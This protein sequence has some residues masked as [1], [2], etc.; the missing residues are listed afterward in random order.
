MI[1]TNFSYFLST[2]N[3]YFFNLLLKERIRWYQGIGELHNEK[4]R[5]E[6]KDSVGVKSYFVIF[7]CNFSEIHLQYHDSIV[8]MQK[9]MSNVVNTMTVKGL[10][11]TQ[12]AK[13]NTFVKF[14]YTCHKFD[15]GVFYM[16]WSS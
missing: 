16:F 9:A 6:K 15:L 7:T 3:V 1:Q 12:R 10:C 13:R 8:N 5:D 2:S 4:R 14:T 11:V